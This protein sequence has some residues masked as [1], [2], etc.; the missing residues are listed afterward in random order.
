MPRLPK[1]GFA[2]TTEQA[3][4]TETP[5][6]GYT[7]A[8]APEVVQAREFLVSYFAPVEAACTICLASYRSKGVPPDPKLKPHHLFLDLDRD[9]IS[10]ATLARLDD[11]LAKHL[12]RAGCCSYFGVSRLQPG[13]RER[14]REAVLCASYAFAEIDFAK[15]DGPENKLA[16]IVNVLTNRAPRPRYL[17]HSG[18]GVH[19]YWLLE[20]PVDREGLPAYEQRLEQARRYLAGDPE[21]TPHP[22]ALLRLPFS[23]NHKPVYASPPRA[24]I[25]FRGNDVGAP[26]FDGE[27]ILRPLR[28]EPGVAP[29]AEEEAEEPA[30]GNGADHDPF[31]AYADY[32]REVIGRPPLSLEE[33]EEALD[34]MRYRGEFRI[35][36]TLLLATRSLIEH[37]WKVEAIVD[38]LTPRVM[39][40]ESPGTRPPW[41]EAAERLD[42]RKMV[43]GW[44]GWLKRRAARA[45]EAEE[46]AQAQEEAPRPNG[47]AGGQEEGSEAGAGA[48]GASGA[49]A[50]GAGATGAGATGAG[51]TGAGAA[52]AGGTSGAGAGTGAGAGAS[53]G[54]IPLPLFPEPA[55]QAAYPVE[56]GLGPLR[57]AAEAIAEQVQIP[58]CIAGSSVIATSSLAAQ[59]L[60]DVK[61]PISLDGTPKPLSLYLLTIAYSGDRKTS[62]DD[63]AQE[64]VRKR[65]EVLRVAYKSDHK[66]WSFLMAAWRAQKRSIE[67][68]KGTPMAKRRDQLAELGDAPPE[69]LKPILTLPDATVE[70]FARNWDIMHGSL[71]LFSSEAG[72]VFG[73]HSFG[74]DRKLRSGAVYS[75]LWDGAGF[76]ELRASG[77][78]A[79]DRLRDHPGRRLAAHL[80]LQPGPAAAVLSD[81]TLRGQ[82]LLSRFLLAAPSSMIGERMYRAPQKAHRGEIAAYEAAIGALFD[83]W[84]EENELHPRHL[85]MDDAAR[86]LWVAFHDEIEGSMKR[87]GPLHEVKDVGSK[88]AEMAVRIGGVLSLVADPECE[89]VSAEMMACGASLA[90]WH[91]YEAQRLAAAWTANPRLL[92][93]KLMLDWLQERFEG[94]EVTIRAAQQYGP[95]R[96]RERAMIADCFKVLTDDYWL[97]PQGRDRWLVI[98][99]DGRPRT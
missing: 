9:S 5:D 98:G 16:H 69:P 82:G 49:G 64:A 85:S 23:V 7:A 14:N 36:K 89:H 83:R 53:P 63:A 25:A 71:G 40:L 61:L 51:A 29:E 12:D 8:P 86:K 10:I 68:A 3:I 76:R 77:E 13:A 45:R 27:P 2:M 95:T 87:G 11:W 84:P 52:G 56:E 1:E 39:A 92:N 55:P 88:T 6:A 81:P 65:E 31:A 37:G 22:A 80:L 18:A 15:I 79:K 35:R 54:P 73:G 32:L 75:R 38:H 42:I 46:K 20:K 48:G 34:R 62:A 58:I 91:A 99:P 17:V 78:E 50:T 90:R 44:P 97:R 4:Q 67:S 72:A 94:S 24:L 60:A 74:A 59:A 47:P 93:A 19:C 57:G 41:S 43:L 70:G 26:D 30:S 33:I 96:L 66:L 21:Y 28:E